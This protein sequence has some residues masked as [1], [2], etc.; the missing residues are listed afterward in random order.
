MNSNLK[1]SEQT[2]KAPLAKNRQ[3]ETNANK[4]PDLLIIND[5]D[6]EEEVNIMDTDNEQTDNSNQN[7]PNRPSQSQAKS[8]N[9]NPNRKA[10]ENGPVELSSNIPPPIRDLIDK[11]IEINSSQLQNGWTEELK[12][13]LLR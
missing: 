1:P 10:V 9:F 6:N 8:I 3:A 7:I 2:V 5:D 12:S 13:L 11:L 4:Q